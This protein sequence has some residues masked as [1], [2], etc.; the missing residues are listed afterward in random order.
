MGIGIEFT[1]NKCGHDYCAISGIGF[2][3]PNE[4]QETVEEIKNGKYG[5]DWKRL[6]ESTPGA[7][8]NAEKEFY[9][10]PDCGAF[11]TEPNLAVYAPKDPTSPKDEEINEYHTPY[12]LQTD[13]HL[14]KSYIHK[15]PKC[16]KRMHKYRVTDYLRCPECNE[17]QME[18]SGQLLWD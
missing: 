2:G 18:P 13:Y 7:A 1:C 11:D 17:G 8:I 4:Y 16:G 9:V 10:C 3:F 14:V 12:E 5:K 6:F 15:C